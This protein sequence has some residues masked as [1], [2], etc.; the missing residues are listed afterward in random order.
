[1]SEGTACT[2]KECTERA[3]HEQRGNDGTVWA[4][5]CAQHH[6]ELGAAIGSTDVRVLLRAWVR[7]GGGAD[8]TARRLD[9]G[10]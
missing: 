6:A 5:L 3:A 1:V 8:A 9:G 4:N 7:A 2:W 10:R